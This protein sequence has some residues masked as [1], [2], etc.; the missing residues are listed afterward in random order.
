V[1]LLFAVLLECTR[2]ILRGQTAFSGED[3]QH[4]RAIVGA[5]AVIVVV[6]GALAWVK[7][8]QIQAMVQQSAQAQVP[9]ASVSVALVQ[10][11]PWPEEV[12]AVGTVTALQGTT[13]RAEVPGRVE[14][15]AFD[16]GDR[17]RAG[18]VLV[19]QDAR[20]ER[21]QYQAAQAAADLAALELARGRRLA[22]EAVLAQAELDRLEAAARQAR[23][24]AEALAALVAKKTIRAPFD[25]MLGIRRVS[26]GQ[27]LAAGDAIVDIQQVEPVQVEFSV[28]QEQA[29]RLSVGLPVEVEVDGGRHT[30]RLQ[31]IEP[32]ADPATR[33]VRALVRLEGAAGGLRP[34]MFVR[35]TVR[36][37]ERRA[38]LAIPATAVLTAPYGDSVF[39]VDNATQ[40]TVAR[41][42]F[43]RLGERRG[44]F[45]AVLSGLNAGQPVVSSGVF[46]LRSG[47]PVV[48]TDAFTLP[49]ELQ[50]QPANE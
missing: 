50:P 38:V 47:Q 2:Y 39:V 13:V 45:V 22:A 49:F 4:W 37:D 26:L 31:S 33:M 9:P 8:T 29:A 25:G 21:A 20:E 43:V 3:M 28:P 16:S 1:E 42:V 6:L 34:G 30:G 12:Q 40:K 23:A 27:S 48:V 46:R 19:V 5:V 10:E 32:Q 15:L 41:Q 14:R 24:Q 17:V 36:Q 18:Q 7:W 35:V 11:M 44:D